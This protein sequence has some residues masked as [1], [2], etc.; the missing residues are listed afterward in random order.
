MA[1]P[2]LRRLGDVADEVIELRSGIGLAQ[3]RQS[4]SQHLQHLHARTGHGKSEDV[5][6]RFKRMVFGQTSDISRVVQKSAMVGLD[7]G[8]SLRMNSQSM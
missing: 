7:V 6:T 8:H 2:V 4:E 5:L 3:R 1:I